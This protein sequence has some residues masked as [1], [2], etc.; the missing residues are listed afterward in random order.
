MINEF[1]QTNKIMTA[2]GSQE[3]INQDINTTND[4]SIGAEKGPTSIKRLSII[5]PAYNEENTIAKILDRIN[6]VILLQNIEKEVIIVNDC[7]KD[8]TEAALLNYM[9]T[10]PNRNTSSTLEK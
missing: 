2:P 9:N 7:S 8:N 3:L 6:E 10:T 1:S 4:Q 5:I